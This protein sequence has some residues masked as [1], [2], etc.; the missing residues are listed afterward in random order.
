MAP[1]HKREA[2]VR[3]R[4]GC[5]TQPSL[6]SGSLEPVEIH[7]SPDPFEPIVVDDSD[8]ECDYAGGVEC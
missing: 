3:A 5:F 1:K 2:A 6:E 7:Q 8:S 4:A